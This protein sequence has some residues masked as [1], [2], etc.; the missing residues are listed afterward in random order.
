MRRLAVAVTLVLVLVVTAC[1]DDSSED[2]AST[3]T[4]APTTTAAAPSSTEP[5]STTLPGTPIDIAPRADARLAVVGVAADDVLNVRRGPGVDFDVVTTLAPLADD[6]V[7]LGENRQLDS[8]AVWAH[9]R[10]DGAEG[11]ANIAF[12]AQLGATTDETAA[13]YPAVADRP[14]AD[15]LSA[16]AEAVAA[17]VA[18]TEPV[19]DVT[20]VDGPTEGDLG[21]VTVDV[22]G[23]G[24]DSVGGYRLHLFADRDGDGWRL[25]TVEQTVLCSRGVDDQGRCA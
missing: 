16:L 22:I 20:I 1:G 24:D 23:I 21:E 8:G 12:L 7:A 3:T 17:D 5:T 14:A 2:G 9:V 25:R 18:S 15:D 19:S 4:G 6:V 11:W 10:A 13:L